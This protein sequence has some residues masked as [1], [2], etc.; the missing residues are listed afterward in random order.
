MT[1]TKMTREVIA[2]FLLSENVD[3]TSEDEIFFAIY[4]YTILANPSWTYEACAEYA[5]G[6]ASELHM[7]FAG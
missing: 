2:S 5:E 1:T 7:E 4:D 3:L 6:L